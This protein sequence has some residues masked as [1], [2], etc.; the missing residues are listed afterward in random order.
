MSITLSRQALYDAVWSKPR[1]ELAKE[2]GISNVAISKH[3]KRERIPVPPVGHWAKKRAGCNVSDIPLPVRWPG[4]SDTLTI[5]RPAR[6]LWYG[7]PKVSEP[8]KAPTF[9]DDMECQVQSASARIGRVTLTRDLQAPDPA[10]ARLLESEANRRAN[11]AAWSYERPRFDGADHQRQLRLFNSLARA[12]GSL[13]GRQDVRCEDEWIRGVGTVHHL[14][15]RLALGVVGMELRFH[16]P[17][18]SRRLQGWTPV[19]TTTLRVGHKH[20]RVPV[21][22]WADGDGS[23]LEHQL[24]DIVRALLRRAELTYRAAAQDQY[25]RHLRLRDE[26]LE[27][28]DARRREEEGRRLAAVEAK[29]VKVRNE[30]LEVARRRSVA[31]GIR[32][33]I[34]AL[35]GHKAASGIDRERLQAWAAHALALAD[36][37]DPMNASVDELLGS[38]EFN[39]AL[40][41]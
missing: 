25:E 5:G 29:K 21:Q 30:I 35:Q 41:S 9:A 20:S 39:T 12:I 28:A 38:F 32:A 24:T 18:D 16:E 14:R 7:A 17:T 27:A 40:P 23:R 19:K 13:Y 10:L 33:T 36:S 34:E 1:T 8:P 3:C 26:Q 37:I 2:F 22:E 15:L 11:G 4:Q 31:M 6:P